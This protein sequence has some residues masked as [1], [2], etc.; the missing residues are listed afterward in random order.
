MKIFILFIFIC[1]SF[2]LEAQVTLQPI[3][4]PVGLIQKNQLWNVVVINGANETYNCKLALVLKDRTTN[5][6]VLTAT[7]AVFTLGTGSKQLNINALNPIQYN[8]SSQGYDNNIEGLIVVGNYIACYNLTNVTDKVL[9]LADECVQFDVE[10]LSPPMLISPGD[11]SILDVAPTQFSWIPPTPSGMFK[12]LQYNVIITPVS[13]GQKAAEAVQQNIP[14]YSE[15]N[16]IPNMLNYSPAY[17]SFEKDKWYAWQIVAKDDN[18]YAAKSEV[19]VFKMSG[20]AP[21]ASGNNNYISLNKRFNDQSIYYINNDVLSI[22]YYCEEKDNIST[23]AVYSTD[24]KLIQK[25]SLKVLYGDNFFS[26]KLKRKIQK[27][28]LFIVELTGE[29]GKKYSSMFSINN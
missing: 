17:S 9:N 25:K 22:R 16:L 6:E 23:I 4:P 28:Q 19:W 5:A 11:S 13:E 8:Y 15:A 2:C 18:N 21:P 7:T 29:N 26:L 3:I 1:F 20:N 27:G 14:L 12:R 24:K 10:P